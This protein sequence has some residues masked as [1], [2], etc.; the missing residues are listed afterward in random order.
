MATF[1]VLL[2]VRNSAEYLS[3]AIDSIRRQTFSDWRL[4][5]LDHGST[6]GSRELALAAADQDQ[7][8]EVHSLPWARGLSDLLNAGLDKCDCRFVLRQD[9]DDISLP[10][11][12]DLVRNAFDASP[13]LM[14]VGGQAIAIDNSGQVTG[15]LRVPSNPEAIAAGCFFYNP[16][17]HPAVAVDF[18]AL[19]D[20]GGAYGRDILGAV[21]EDD[22]VT[23]SGLVEDYALF[24]QM[25]LL[26]PC[27]NLAAPLIKY[28]I[29]G[30]SVSV[31]NAHQQIGLSLCVS[32]FLAHSFSARTACESFDPAPFCNHADHV[33]DFLQDDYSGEYRQMALA[34]RHGFGPSRELD[35]ELAFRWVLATRNSARMIGRYLEFEMKYGGMPAER[36]TVR[37]WL[38]RNVRRGKFIYRA[39]QGSDAAQA[40]H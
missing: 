28:R 34:L 8:V 26:G 12:M 36:R 6:D 7:R 20:L 27:R 15:R 22:A 25:A 33:F 31:V 39:S 2:P 14:L 40:V 21:S 29:H 17:L 38:L 4:L 9:A 11:R 32:R 16:V 24:G 30:G 23:V 19:R 5:V 10:H 35:R 37:N 3:D 18:M 13:S 1:D